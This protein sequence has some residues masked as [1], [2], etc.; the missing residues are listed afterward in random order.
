MTGESST[1]ITIY[2]EYVTVRDLEQS[3]NSVATVKMTTKPRR[4]I[5]ISY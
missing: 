5:L 3:F 2:L 4:M 1:I